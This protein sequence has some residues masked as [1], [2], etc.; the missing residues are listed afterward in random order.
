[1]IML[2]TAA[3]LWFWKDLALFIAYGF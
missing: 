2:A 1:V 3:L